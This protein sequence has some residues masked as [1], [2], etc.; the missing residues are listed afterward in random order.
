MRASFGDVQPA[1]RARAPAGARSA[2]IATSDARSS[3]S[4]CYHSCVQPAGSFG[5]RAARCPTGRRGRVQHAGPASI[6]AQ[7]YNV[8]Y[9]TLGS[10][11]DAADAT[12]DAFLNAFRN[13][14]SFNGPSSGLK[15]WLL[16]IA[17]NACYDQSPAA[18]AATVREPRR[19]DGGRGRPTTS[20][21]CGRP[22]R[23]SRARARAAQ[24]GLRNGSRDPGGDR[25]TAARAAPDRDPVRRPG[26]QLRGGRPGDVR[27]AGNREEPAEPR[28]SPAARHAD[29]KRG[30]AGKLTAFSSMKA[31]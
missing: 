16:R 7:L 6:S 19:T 25:S 5:R 20:H 10:A 27:R 17:V 29:G 8:C 23:R 24:P 28:P 2:A 21:E 15:A 18:P 26:S 3:L 12:Q 14:K 11:E 30:T 31:K 1:T 22:R 4:G 13:L 9:R